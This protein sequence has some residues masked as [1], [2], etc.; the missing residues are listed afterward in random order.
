MIWVTISLDG[1]HCII[2]NVTLDITT[3]F[4]QYYTD[5]SLWSL[6][7]SSWYIFIMR[8]NQR[9]CIRI[10]VRN[11]G[12]I[13]HI[14][15]SHSEWPGINLRQCAGPT[16]TRDWRTIT[17]YD[18]TCWRQLSPLLQGGGGGVT[19]S[20]CRSWSTFLDSAVLIDRNA[21]SDY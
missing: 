13:A 16:W 21:I 5:L 17:Y 12:I 14:N 11:W 2:S 4:N 6:L 10:L 9:Y 3:F 1:L 15:S 7:P 8:Y 19:H 18:V 20:Y